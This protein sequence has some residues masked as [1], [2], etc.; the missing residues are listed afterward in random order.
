M[1]TELETSTKSTV[2]GVTLDTAQQVGLRLRRAR[3]SYGRTTAVISARIKVREHYLIAIEEGQWN[4]LPPGLNGRGLVRIYA[5]ELAVTVPEL[6][7]AANQTV[8]PAEHDAQAPYQVGIHKKES[9][10]VDREFGHLRSIAEPHVPS[11]STLRAVETPAR[12]NALNSATKSAKYIGAVESHHAKPSQKAHGVHVIE[13]MPDEEPLDVVTPDV[14][15]ILGINLDLLQ[16]I[17]QKQ[18]TLEV[19]PAPR[20]APTPAVV[21][22][23]TPAEGPVEQGLTPTQPISEADLSRESSEDHQLQEPKHFQHSRK[24]NK[25]H[26]RDRH[27]QKENL[28]QEVSV[29]EPMNSAARIEEQP[30]TA[31]EPTLSQSFMLS[32]KGNTSEFPNSVIASEGPV[33]STQNLQP[34]DSIYGVRPEEQTQTNKLRTVVILFAAS[35]ALFF[36]GRAIFKEK[37][38][39]VTSE[40]SQSTTIPQNAN[41]AENKI[42]NSQSSSAQPSGMSSGSSTEQDAILTNETTT[43]AASPDNSDAERAKSGDASS[44]TAAAP[45]QPGQSEQTASEA[46]GKAAQVATAPS[47]SQASAASATTSVTEGEQSVN[48]SDSSA[49]PSGGAALTL[50]EPTE[51]Q[52]KADGQRVYAGLH[53]AGKIDIKFKKQA[54]IFVQ[55]G[56]KARLKYSGWDH[57]LLGQPGRKRRILLN[58]QSF[59]NKP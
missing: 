17:P 7:Q 50:L 10:G 55:D 39:S 18:S 46:S 31:V 15:S 29:D 14:A 44:N 57:G 59:A 23:P 32:E 1:G 41:S 56:S 6:D 25:R 8:M 47:S 19:A 5:R 21:L 16:E 52:I 48:P 40:E 27:E 54:E 34:N 13:K 30:Q 33:Q 12:V 22:E 45:G 51:I 49:S 26:N 58:A 42:E 3:E 11:G 43:Q 36:A 37:P 53:A 28:I 4:Q 24:K 9:H 20:P 35:A 2:L 38:S